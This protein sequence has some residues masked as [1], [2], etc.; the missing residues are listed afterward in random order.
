MVNDAADDP[1]LLH[2]AKL[3]DQHFLGNSLD[4]ALEI[5]EAQHLS[6]KEVKQ[7][8]ELPAPIDQLERILDAFSRGFSRILVRHTFSCVPYFFV[9]SCAF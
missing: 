5:G 1:V 2:L 6:T 9:R 8:D 7:D 4:R 3:L